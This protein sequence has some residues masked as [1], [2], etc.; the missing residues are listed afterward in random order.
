MKSF[1][2]QVKKITFFLGLFG[3]IVPWAAYGQEAPADT[4]DWNTDLKAILA[5][6]Q[7]SYDNWVEGGINS[8]A[9]TASLDGA[10]TR[11][12]PNWVQKYEARFA[13]GALK[14]DTL[15]VR[16]ADDIIRLGAVL[17]F[18]NETSLAQ[19]QPTLSATLRTQFA[20]GFDY[21]TDPPTKVSAFFAPAVLTQTI[22][23]TYE[24][25]EWFTWLMG[26]AAKETVVSIERFREDFG[27]DPDEAVRF[28]PGFDTTLKLNRDVVENVNLKSTLNVFGAFGQ[29]DKPDIR[30]ENLV[31]MQ[32]NAWLTVNF[33]F[34]AFYDV[35]IIDEVQLKQVLSTGVSIRI[36]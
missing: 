20:E 15:D 32:V 28:E 7:A 29:I 2:L 24:P 19:W 8:L 34:V 1:L 31:T 16:K 6:S 5:G 11:T 13:I 14:Q 36:L 23:F 3:C 35:D 22:G 30:W 25:R 26:V 10:A 17:Q 33:E 12:T 4:S 27:N 21:D 9:F 18:K